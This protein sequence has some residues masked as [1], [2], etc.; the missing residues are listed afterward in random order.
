MTEI[1]K[2][3]EKVRFL[4]EYEIKIKVVLFWRIFTFSNFLYLE[5]NSKK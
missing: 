4:L 1:K 2:V 5:I 3:T